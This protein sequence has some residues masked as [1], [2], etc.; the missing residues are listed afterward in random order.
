MC[1]HTQCINAH[2]VNRPELIL[3]AIRVAIKESVLYID[4]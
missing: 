4:V 2:L 1:Q 3:K